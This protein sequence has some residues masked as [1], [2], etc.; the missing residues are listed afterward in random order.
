MEVDHASREIVVPHV[1]ARRRSHRWIIAR[2]V[3]GSGRRDAARLLRS[4]ADDADPDA[5]MRR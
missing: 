2:V 3:L 1:D 5:S 4:V